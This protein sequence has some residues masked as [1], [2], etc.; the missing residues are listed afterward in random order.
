MT[1]P[2]ATPPDGFWGWWFGTTRE[3]EVSPAEPGSEPGTFE[4]RLGDYEDDP[5]QTISGDVRLEAKATYNTGNGVSS[6]SS[7]D[8]VPIE[9]MPWWEYVLNWILRHWL[10]LLLL[11]L[12]ALVIA[13]I[14]LELT[15]KRMPRIQPVL[16]GAGDD[17][18]T[19]EIPLQYKP[20]D[21]KHRIWPPWA[22]ESNTFKVAPRDRGIKLSNF[23]EIP[24]KGKTLTIEAARGRNGAKAVRLSE[25]SVKSLQS[26]EKGRGSDSGANP[27]YMNLD[28]VFGNGDGFKFKGQKL[29]D[30]GMGTQETYTSRM[31]IKFNRR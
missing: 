10:Q 17:K 18:Y 20:K 13:F 27:S 29:V 16:V 11:L 19:K 8:T 26:Q 2:D 24:L 25:G 14:V 21:I 31:T 1:C 12:I 5:F 6:G 28:G 7:V 30:T 3:I 22:P 4:V 9:G 23:A 15:K